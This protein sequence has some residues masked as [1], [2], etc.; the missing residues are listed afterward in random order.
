[1]KIVS[2]AANASVIKRNA[3]GGHH[4]SEKV[5]MEPTTKCNQILFCWFTTSHVH[6]PKTGG[7]VFPF[8]YQNIR[9]MCKIQMIRTQHRFRIIG[10][11]IVIQQCT[12]YLYMAGYN[13]FPPSLCLSH[14]PSFLCSVSSTN[15]AIYRAMRFLLLPNLLNVWQFHWHI[16]AVV[17]HRRSSAC[18]CWTSILMFMRSMHP[19][20]NMHWI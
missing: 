15:V 14:F 8:T 9:S 19:L 17:D 16:F 10:Y 12:E 20:L 4:I 2:L 1:M 5:E 3:R 11:W 18:K 6:L 7:G 13:K